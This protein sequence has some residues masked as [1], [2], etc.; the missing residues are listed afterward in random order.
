MGRK[1][2]GINLEMGINIY[3]LCCVKSLQS[4]PARCNHIDYIAHQ[5]LL[6]TGL[7]RQEY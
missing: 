6:S 4:S 2:R 5:A 3:T 1:A 7:S